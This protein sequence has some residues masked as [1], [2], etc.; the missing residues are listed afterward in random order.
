V[1]DEAA[2]VEVGDHFVEDGA[3]AVKEF[4]G[5]HFLLG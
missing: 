2:F 3:E 1:E 5:V 4:R